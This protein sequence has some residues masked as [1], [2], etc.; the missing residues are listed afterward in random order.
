MPTI[1]NCARIRNNLGE[2]SSKPE[3]DLQVIRVRG[4]AAP[5]VF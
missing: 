2:G 1:K 5:Q 4:A 3:K